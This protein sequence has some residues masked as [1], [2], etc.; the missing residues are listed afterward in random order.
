[1]TNR[2]VHIYMQPRFECSICAGRLKWQ[3]T[4]KVAQ[5]EIY[6]CLCNGGYWT[7]PIDQTAIP[8]QKR[9][10]VFTDSG[11]QVETTYTDEPET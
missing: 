5:V 4:M 3:G 6:E 8:A 2:M 9:D 11:E 1:M 10:W 7:H